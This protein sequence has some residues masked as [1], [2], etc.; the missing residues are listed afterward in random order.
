MSK[1]ISRGSIG[2]SKHGKSGYTPKS[3]KLRHQMKRDAE[4]NEVRQ[5]NQIQNPESS[6]K[7]LFNKVK[8]Y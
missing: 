8:S 6:V 2:V 5:K 7:N 4:A 1:Q 3:P